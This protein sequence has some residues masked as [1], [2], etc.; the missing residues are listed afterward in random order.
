MHN[1]NKKLI[2]FMHANNLTPKDVAEMLSVNVDTVYMWRA[3]NGI[4]IIPAA[5]FELLELKTAAKKTA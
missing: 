3:S 1:R 5:K 2:E 4:R